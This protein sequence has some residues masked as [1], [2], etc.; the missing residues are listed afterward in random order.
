MI[1]L[2]LGTREV[3]DGDVVV[4]LIG[5]EATLKTYR[6]RGRQVIFEAANPDYADVDESGNDPFIDPTTE[7]NSPQPE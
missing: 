1:V 4:A 6:K 5:E 7:I 3:R 2:D